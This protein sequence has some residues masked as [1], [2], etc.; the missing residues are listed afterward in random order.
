ML[1]NNPAAYLKTG[2]V[3][4][5][6]HNVHNWTHTGIITDIG[7][8]LLH[9]IEGNTGEGAREGFKVLPPY[10][11]SG[12]RSGGWGNTPKQAADELRGAA[13]QEWL[14]IRINSIDR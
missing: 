6:R 10:Q 5:V 4:L 9:T 7:N 3:F 2:D 11:A 8:E 14:C 12:Q 1:A 13:H